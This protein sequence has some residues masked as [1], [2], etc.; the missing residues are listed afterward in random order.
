MGRKPKDKF[1]LSFGSQQDIFEQY[2]KI[3]EFTPHEKQLEFLKLPNRVRVFAAAN[4]GGKTTIATMD[5]IYAALGIHP[6]QDYPPPPLRL[7]VIGPSFDLVVN[8]HHLPR[9]LEIL[10]KGS[11]SWS[12]EKRMLELFNGTTIEF[13]SYDQELQKFSAVSLHAVWFDEEPPER[14]FNENLMRVIDTRGKLLL[15]FTPLHG[16]NWLYQL[17][18]SDKTDPVT[19]EP[20]VGLVTASIWDNPHVP[21][22]EV[23]MIKAFCRDPD[24]LAARL[25]GKFFTRAGLIY[26]EFDRRFHVVDPFPIP[27]D[28]MICISI[29]HHVRNPQAVIFAAIDPDDNIWVYDEFY[30]HALVP[31]VCKAIKEKTMGRKIALAIID[32]NAATPDAITGKSAKTEY[33]QHGIYVVPAKK[34]K[35]SVLEGIAKVRDYFV[36]GKLKI[37]SNCRETIRQIEIYRW[38]EYSTK[39]RDRHDPKEA[40]LKKEDHLCDSLRMLVHAEPK[41]RPPSMTVTKPHY[42]PLFKK[43]GY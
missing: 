10:P 5:F 6:F 25:E 14:V 38:A 7:R 37:F 35:G 3:F 23:E 39:M 12:A 24:E 42:E 31:E 8:K 2:K 29:D 43:T 27:E 22:E 19:G 1:D 26:K 11:W 30:E 17:I 18:H 9:F 16:M 20:L 32:V 4:R 34:G 36:K 21:L 15:T 28:W 40:P 41:Y 33:W 13:M